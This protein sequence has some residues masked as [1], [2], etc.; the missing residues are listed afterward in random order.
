MAMLYALNRSQLKRIRQSDLIYEFRGVEM[1]SALFRTD[2][3]VARAALPKPLAPAD[4][5]LAQAF[6]ARYP[7]TNFG[8]TYSEGALFLRAVYK[9]EP[10]WY[11]LAMPV[12]ND[13]AMVG[14]REH[15]GYPKKIAEE[16]TLERTGNHVIGRVVRRGVEVLHIEAELTDTVSPSTLDAVGLEAADLEG[17]P[18]RKGV[19]FLFKFFPSPD[20]RGFDYVPRLVREVVLFRP[21]DD[22]RSGAGKLE[23]A[24]S[25]YDP[26]GD[27]PVRD[28]IDVGYGTWDNDMLPGR[29]VARVKNPLS[30]ARHAM[31]KQDYVGWALDRDELP[32][33]LKRRERARRWKALQQY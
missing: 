17:R 12:D 19:S 9:D 8:V 2:P 4:E 11:C 15:F 28:L 24:S 30:F 6:V 20:G 23:L 31:F 16:I 21:R 33:P 14:G 5:P 26:L 32:A 18:C 25:P 22:L 7:E 27:I 29:V 13:M 1:L 10:G 3:D